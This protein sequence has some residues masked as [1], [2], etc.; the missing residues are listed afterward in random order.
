MFGDKAQHLLDLGGDVC[1]HV[2][3]SV[4]QFCEPF[5]NFVEKLIHDIHWYKKYSSIDFVDGPQE[6]VFIE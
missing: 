3:N 6:I 4:R 2:H 5:E 1:H